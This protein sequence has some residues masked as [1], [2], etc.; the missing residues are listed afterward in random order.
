MLFFLDLAF[1]ESIFIHISRIFQVKINEAIQF[2]F[3]GQV[4][5]V[6]SDMAV[7]SWGMPT[8]HSMPRFAG[9]EKD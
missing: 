4:F 8:S 2:F 6:R 7:G 9:T 3:G 5:S 1:S